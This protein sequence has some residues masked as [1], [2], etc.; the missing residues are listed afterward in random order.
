MSTL[1]PFSV[2]PVESTSED[3]SNDGSP[4]PHENT[5]GAIQAQI[6]PAPAP[7]PATSRAPAVTP[8]RKGVP[9]KV[10]DTDFKDSPRVNKEWSERKEQ[11]YQAMSACQAAP[12]S[13]TKPKPHHKIV[14]HFRWPDNDD[15]V[16]VDPK[17]YTATEASSNVPRQEPGTMATS[18]IPST[19]PSSTPIT[20]ASAIHRQSSNAAVTATTGRTL[21]Q[22][23]ANTSPVKSALTSATFLPPAAM[24]MSATQSA[25]GPVSAGSIAADAAPTSATKGPA[26]LPQ[27]ESTAI[28]QSTK[29]SPAK[30]PAAPQVAAPVAHAAPVAP[31]GPAIL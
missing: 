13:P 16:P 12:G 20:S 30:A 8:T 6:A 4:T 18:S 14:G 29:A 22:I 1:N 3:D 26:P 27:H 25:P 10:D 31:K 9:R 23:V 5:D 28:Q 11:H 17:F 19:Q 21:A 2:L 15:P 7:L 24:P